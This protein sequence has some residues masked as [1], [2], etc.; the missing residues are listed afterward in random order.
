[1]LSD[2]ER[3]IS[4]YTRKEIITRGWDYYAKGQ[5]KSVQAAGSRLLAAVEGS[6]R[7]HVGLGA[8]F[9]DNA[10][11]CP[12]SGWC[13]HMAAVYFAALE[14]QGG[15]PKRAL[16][17]MTGAGP[18]TVSR[19][20]KQPA[21]DLGEPPAQAGTGSLGEQSS[22][23]EWM[24]WME[25]RFGRTWQ[26]C[27]HTLHPLQPVLSALKGSARDW[28][29]PLQ[30]MHWMYSILFIL[31]QAERAIKLSDPFSRYYQEM[32]FTRMAEPWI[33]HYY[34][35]AERQAAESA[36]E[37]GRAW[38]KELAAYLRG[39]AASPEA[40]LFRWDQLYLG[41]ISPL[42]S[43]PDWPIGERAELERLLEHARAARR[44]AAQAA[45]AGEAA[46]EEE[47]GLAFAHAA[48][49]YLDA[50]QG[51]DAKAVERLG[52]T[53]PDAAAGLA[54]DYARTRLEQRGWEAFSIWM[55][56]LDP[57]AG[58]KRG[59]LLTSYLQLCREA[60][61]ASPSDPSWQR[62]MSDKLPYSYMSLADLLLEKGCFEEWADLQLAM[63]LRPDELDP[64]D[65][66]LISKRAPS[67]MIP[68]Y[69][70]AVEGWISMR[71][72]QSYRMAVKQL[73]KLEKLYA[74]EKRT[75]AWTAYLD[76]TVS[77]YQRMRAFQE[78][79]RKGTMLK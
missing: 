73:K 64:A 62:R 63:G 31:E 33:E 4:D 68:L 50:A 76:R 3:K 65:L 72:R 38:Q 10:C 69:H 41:F 5:V 70:Q 75:E 51:E 77:K 47:R 28:P 60:D 71:N 7:Y 1:M 2:I 43:D 46:A 67:V 37:E 48:L 40:K 21:A 79:L 35:L 66:R 58:A 36:G 27:R 55:D 54:L 59:N 24:E 12:Y 56:F 14:Q 15:E 20:E 61:L 32:S 57:I 39:Q 25:H 8:R 52:Q 49:A 30:A 53:P 13:K 44:A 29:K 45:P 23:R 11:D 16:E 74:A 42:L 17:R 19:L 9:D 78:E 22:P 34:S 18:V 26:G 6:E